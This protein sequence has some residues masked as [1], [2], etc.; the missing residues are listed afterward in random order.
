MGCVDKLVARLSASRTWVEEER[1]GRLRLGIVWEGARFLREVAK[2]PVENRVAGGW[3]C[4]V[5]G[6]RVVTRSRR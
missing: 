2:R 1:G 4:G 3:G 5:R 6:R